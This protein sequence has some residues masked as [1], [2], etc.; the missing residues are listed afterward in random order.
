VHATHNTYK[1]LLYTSLNPYKYNTITTSH[2]KHSHD[3]ATIFAVTPR[4]N[5]DDDGQGWESDRSY[6]KTS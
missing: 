2:I 5:S 3:Y 4:R 1:L 6:W